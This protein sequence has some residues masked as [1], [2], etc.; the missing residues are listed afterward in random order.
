M[1][2]EQANIAQQADASMPMSAYKILN[3]TYQHHKAFV[4]K[5]PETNLFPLV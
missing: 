4:Q 1:F 3:Y 5:Y 2:H